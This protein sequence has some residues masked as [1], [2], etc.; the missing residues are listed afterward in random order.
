MKT[1]PRPPADVLVGAAEAAFIAGLDPKELHRVVDETVLPADLLDRRAVSRRFARLS[2]ALAR[3]YFDTAHE[4]TKT[5]RIEVI[6]RLV[7]RL[8]TQENREALLGLAGP[9]AAFDWS[10]RLGDLTV[11]LR[12]A[13]RSAA[14]RAVR[15]RNALALV[16]EDPDMLGGRPTFRGTRV[17]IDV[18]IGAATAGESWDRLRRSYP[19]LTEDHVDAANVYAVIRP[20]RGRPARSARGAKHWRVRSTHRV[21]ASRR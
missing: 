5:A 19:F 8:R 15:A 21:P 14:E 11:D 20:R 16:V 7:E 3:F 4:L 6:E 10:L 1:A 12:N 17:P 2:A 18:A 13:V 9:L